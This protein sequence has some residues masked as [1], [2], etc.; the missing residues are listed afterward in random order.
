MAKDDFYSTL[1]DV[2]KELERRN[3]RAAAERLESLS[4]QLPFEP[5]E[6]FRTRME[7]LLKAPDRSLS[8]DDSLICSHCGSS[9]DLT[10]VLKH[11]EWT[12]SNI[13]IDCLEETIENTYP[14]VEDLSEL[15]G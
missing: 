10:K 11:G 15:Y 4:E 3:I 14:T 8:T 9:C 13:C 2:L 7:A 5:S 6:E 12:G 1:C